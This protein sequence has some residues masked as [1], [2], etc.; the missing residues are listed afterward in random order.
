MLLVDGPLVLVVQFLKAVRLS[1]D[2]SKA[3]SA[4][5][6]LLVGDLLLQRSLLGGLVPHA[7]LVLPASVGLLLALHIVSDLG[8]LLVG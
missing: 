7:L 3:L 6:R 1:A 2:V 8:V 5:Q 4:K